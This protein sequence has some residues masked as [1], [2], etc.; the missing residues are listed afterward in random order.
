M[1]SAIYKD[2]R[3][4]GRVLASELEKVTPTASRIVLAI[5]RGGVA[6]GSELAR[7][8]ELPLGVWLSVKIRAP[9]QSELAVGA[10]SHN[11]EPL[12][13]S[14]MMARLELR[15]EDLKD[16]IAS[17]RR[18]LRERLGRMRRFVPEPETLRGKEVIY[19]D[20]GIATGSTMLAGMKSLR[21]TGCAR[22]IAA[23]PVGPP[24]TVQ[25]LREVADEVVC[26]HCPSD[27]RAVQAFYAVFSQ[28][29]ETEALRLL[30]A[31]GNRG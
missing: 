3:Q 26:P 18:E 23:A 19:V 8:L 7:V 20:D 16:E 29:P 21:D 30:K 22:L 24:E 12:W 13:D 5:P 4:A 1:P 6:V 31:V 10:L 17:R 15:P 2:R 9:Q 27:F 28:L 14:D 11:G 25:R